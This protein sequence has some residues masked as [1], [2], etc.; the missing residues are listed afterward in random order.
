LAR[1]FLLRRTAVSAVFVQVWKTGNPNVDRDL[2]RPVLRKRNFMLKA[3]SSD[4]N[5]KSVRHL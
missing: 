4:S 2:S 5:G 3:G 1:G